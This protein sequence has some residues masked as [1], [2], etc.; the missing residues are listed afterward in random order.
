[1]YTIQLS[2]DRHFLFESLHIYI[3]ASP[4]LRWQR[5]IWMSGMITQNSTHPP[6]HLFIHAS[7][8]WS[9][10]ATAHNGQ[11][12][13][14]DRS[15][16]ISFIYKRNQYELKD[17][18]HT[19]IFTCIYACSRGLFRSWMMMI[20]IRRRRRRRARANEISS[21]EIVVFFRIILSI[22]NIYSCA[23]HRD[24][25]F[26]SPHASAFDNNTIYMIDQPH[27]Y[28]SR[29]V[30]PPPFV[31]KC[32][33]FRRPWIAAAFDVVPRC[34][35]SAWE[36]PRLSI[37]ALHVQID[38]RIV[39]ILNR[40]HIMTTKLHTT[41]LCATIIVVLVN[42]QSI[43]PIHHAYGTWQRKLTFDI[44]R[45]IDLYIENKQ[46]AAS[47]IEKSMMMIYIYT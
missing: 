5:S 3:L 23:P 30:L 12:K 33:R 1:M 6:T 36:L 47:S 25:P 16:D 27:T 38:D 45:S 31:I 42:Y 43:Y 18:F 41:S 21:I 8:H 34:C 32:N 19:M 4:I 44:D 13:S 37:F 40:I 17:D 29:W 10:Q 28:V 9:A 39:S 7:S 22:D 20:I 24:M 14:M 15:I 46:S 26:Q 2:N 35:C 11:L